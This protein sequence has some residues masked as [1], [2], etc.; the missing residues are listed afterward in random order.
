[1]IGS[2]SKMISCR[3]GVSKDCVNVLTDGWKWCLNSDISHRLGVLVAAKSGSLFAAS[4]GPSKQEP[5]TAVFILMTLPQ[6]LISSAVSPFRSAESS[7]L[8]SDSCCIMDRRDGLASSKPDIRKSNPAAMGGELQL[9]Q[10]LRRLINA[11]A[12]WHSIGVCYDLLL[13]V[14]CSRRTQLTY[15][16]CH[17]SSRYDREDLKREYSFRV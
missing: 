14:V 3:G 8:G 7:A 12:L 2:P 13:L 4:K 6:S 11:I 9:A 10:I 15:S 5:V 1:M 17:P 16:R